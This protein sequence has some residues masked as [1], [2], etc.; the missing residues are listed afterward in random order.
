[1]PYADRL[2]TVIGV[3]SVGGGG[4]GGG[5]FTAAAFKSPTAIC[6]DPLSPANFFIGDLN[7][8]RYCELH[9]TH[10]LS[11]I[12]G[13]TASTGTA[14]STGTASGIIR[15]VAGGGALGCRDSTTPSDVQFNDI[16]SLVIT[17]VGTSLYAVDHSNCQIRRVSLSPGPT[18][19]VATATTTVA[20]GSKPKT[21]DGPASASL[22]QHPTR[23]VFHRSGGGGGVSDESVLWISSYRAIRRFDLRANQVTTLKLSRIS[24]DDFSP[25]AIDCFA[26]D[27]LIVSCAQTASLYIINPTTGD[28]VVVSGGGKTGSVGT[29]ARMVVVDHEHAMYYICRNQLWRVDFSDSKAAAALF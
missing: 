11:T 25:H 2:S 13:S 3:P 28:A 8:I 26:S 10:S 7:S 12:D 27:L 23:M 18:G 9:S 6:I 1:M 5:G 14:N 16:H 17:R 22:L 15:L 4:G 20:G 29:D 19:P 24:Y 21:V